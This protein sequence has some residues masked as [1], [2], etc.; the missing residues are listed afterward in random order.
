MKEI[1]DLQR[2]MLK[3]YHLDAMVTMTPENITYVTGAYIPTQVTVRSRKVIHIITEKN[4]PV[5]IVVNIEEPI[6][7]AQSWMDPKSIISYNEFTQNP[8]MIAIDKLKEFGMETKRI[9]MELSYLSAIDMDLMHRELPHAEIVN[10]DAAYE[11]MRFIKMQFELDRIISFGS[12]IEEV[13]YGAFA[14]ARAGMTEKDIYRFISNGF[15]EIAKGDKMSMPMVGSGVRSCLLNGEPTDKVLEKGDI[16]RVDVMGTKDNYYCDCCRTAVVGT[17]T[18][19]Q[20]ETWSK[21]VKAHDDAIAQIKPGVSTKTIY[22]NFARQ[23]TEWGFKPVAFIGHGLGLTLHEEPY[24]N[25]YKDTTLREN[26][27]LCVEPIH[28]IDGEC[29]YQLENEVLVTADGHRMITGTHHPYQQLATIRRLGRGQLP[30]RPCVELDGGGRFRRRSRRD[31]RSR[32]RS[33][34]LSQRHEAVSAR[35]HRAL[36]ES[37]SHRR[38]AARGAHSGPGPH[39]RGEHAQL[40]RPQNERNERACEQQR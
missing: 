14:S 9:G 11:E 23:F 31:E 22:D 24:I 7:R 32:H 4:D 25:T 12:N 26:M 39:R 10:A 8:M 20:A 5:V 37:R 28:V 1:T 27:V 16:V 3:K 40:Y 2:E 17:P 21:L 15:A 35:R 38:R 30:R 34:A 36:Y 13:I 19:H 29:G 18:E 33:R 6:M